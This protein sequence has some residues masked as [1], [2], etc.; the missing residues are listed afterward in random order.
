MP[1]LD[2]QMWFAALNPSRA[3]PWLTGLMR[4]ILRGS[5]EILDLLADDPFSGD[6][7]RF[8]RLV[9]YQFR[10]STPEERHEQAVWWTR[11]L[12]GPLT[13]AISRQ[14]LGLK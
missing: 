4:G 6:P 3:E 11:E 1:R 9:R 10:F 5:P 7:P 14:Q 12:Q 8:I 2:W 13:P